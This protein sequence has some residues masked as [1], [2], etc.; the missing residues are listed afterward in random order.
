MNIWNRCSE[1]LLEILRIELLRIRSFAFDGNS[2]QAASIA[3]HVHNIP[4]ILRSGQLDLV[5][6]YLDVD[7]A[8]YVLTQ[9]NVSPLSELW[10]EL[11]HL[12]KRIETKTV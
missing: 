3:D 4:N 10:D 2:L 7:V 11:G 1:L 6:S 5:R 12:T 8:S 9:G